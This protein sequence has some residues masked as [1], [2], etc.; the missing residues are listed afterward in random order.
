MD[1]SGYLQKAGKGHAQAYYQAQSWHEILYWERISNCAGMVARSAKYVFKVSYHGATLWAELALSCCH[2]REERPWQQVQQ[3]TIHMY[4]DA[5]STP[6]RVAAVLF[7]LVSALIRLCWACAH[8]C[9]CQGMGI[10]TLQTWNLRLKCWRS[11]ALGATMVSCLSNCCLLPLVCLVALPVARFAC[12][13]S[14]CGL[15]HFGIRRYDFWQECGH[16]F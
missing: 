3:R 10:S 9:L 11:S 14:C 1:H 2:V 12:L 8:F 7:R 13:L 6:P 16:L 15:R 4:T 5:R